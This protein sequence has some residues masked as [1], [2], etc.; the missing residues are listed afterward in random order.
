MV[1]ALARIA[2]RSCR[3]SAAGSQTRA[4]VQ[5]GSANAWLDEARIASAVERA[6]SKK[7][8]ALAGGL[9][10]AGQVLALHRQLAADRLAFDDS[11]AAW[12]HVFSLVPFVRL[13]IEAVE[14]ACRHEATLR[15]LDR[16]ERLAYARMSRAVCR[17]PRLREEFSREPKP[18]ARKRGRRNETDLRDF[19][20]NLVRSEYP[21]SGRAGAAWRAG[22]AVAALVW[23]RAGLMF[24]TKL[25]H[26]KRDGR[27]RM[28]SFERPQSRACA[29]FFEA[30]ADG[31]YARVLREASTPLGGSEGCF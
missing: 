13:A 6:C 4:S 14:K 30:L 12:S 23:P 17:A 24:E 25:E 8:V 20:I 21:A 10:T 3:S 26:I 1:T 15:D 7:A 28:R 18:V 19:V 22:V 11:W 5:R 2:P 27:R 31:G 9:V 16:E 29:Y